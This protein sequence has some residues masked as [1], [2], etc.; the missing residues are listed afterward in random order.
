MFVIE[1]ANILNYKNYN[2]LS[3]DWLK[4]LLFS[5]N[6]LC[7]VVIGQ[8]V[9]GQFVNISNVP[10]LSAPFSIFCVHISGKIHPDMNPYF[11]R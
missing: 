6:L 8:F 2:F 3:W 9:I 1:F 11:H 4:K 7:Q 5:T 10:L